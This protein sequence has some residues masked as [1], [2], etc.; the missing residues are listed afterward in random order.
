VVCENVIIH[1]FPKVH[2]SFAARFSK[3]T[4]SANPTPH[5]PVRP[6]LSTTAFAVNPIQ[7]HCLLFLALIKAM[8]KN[9]EP[10]I[11]ESHRQ[12]YTPY[13]GADPIADA[14]WVCCGCG[15]S[16]QT[17]EMRNIC[18]RLQSSVRL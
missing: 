17:K 4:I 15:A 12:H 13:P 1:S 3:L 6:S 7:A 14:A 11:K 2:Q 9:E 8:P 18:K 16:W 5:T 10:G